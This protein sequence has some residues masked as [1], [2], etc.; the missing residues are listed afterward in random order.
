MELGW[1]ID[2]FPSK[3][4]TSEGSRVERQERLTSQFIGARKASYMKSVH[5]SRPGICPFFGAFH[6]QLRAAL[7]M[8]S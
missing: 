4:S 8:I 6:Y 5:N 2:L 3:R 1:Q 7:R